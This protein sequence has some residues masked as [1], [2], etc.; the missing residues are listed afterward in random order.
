MR[1]F[2]AFL[3]EVRA[4]LDR[5]RQDFGDRSLER[6]CAEL[7]DEIRE[8]LC[9]VAGWAAVMWA[10][11]ERLRAAAERLDPPRLPLVGPD[12]DDALDAQ[13]ALQSGPERE[14]A[15]RIFGGR[16]T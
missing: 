10:R 8:E 11:L 1:D 7:V 14:H 5:G 16:R 6:P 12:R 13:S 15:A 4:R 9:D 2:D 3:A